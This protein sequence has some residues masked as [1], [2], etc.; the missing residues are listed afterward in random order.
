MSS[1]RFLESV[2]DLLVPGYTTRFDWGA[3]WARPWPNGAAFEWTTLAALA[4]QVIQ[5]GWHCSFPIL[6]IPTGEAL[7]PLRN[8]IPY[9]H[10]AQ[11]GHAGANRHT[12]SLA[13]RFL[14]SL[15]PKLILEKDEVYYSVFREGCPYHEIMTGRIYDDRPD[16]LFLAG[17]PTPG[18]PRLIQDEKEVDFSFD[19]TKGPTISGRLRVVNSRSLPCRVRSPK[20]GL[21][22]PIAGIV[23]CSINKLPAVASAQL[24]AYADL[25]ASQGRIPPLFLITGNDLSSLPWA[26]ASIDLAHTN[27]HLLENDFRTGANMILSHFGLV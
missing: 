22:I 24:Q 8:E 15:I 14:Q 21:A 6:Q 26:N 19:F 27:L 1:G 3:M 5:Q 17:R 4:A 2:A 23:E 16:I 12:Y 10:G 7:F 11:A 13:L 9:H 20:E 25:F 18:F